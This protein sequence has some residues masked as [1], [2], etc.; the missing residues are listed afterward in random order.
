M[1]NIKEIGK[2]AKNSEEDAELG[3]RRQASRTTNGREE[4]VKRID[5]KREKTGD[6]ENL[7]PIGNKLAVWIQD[8]VPP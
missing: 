3:V 7:V 1:Q 8:L 6:E 2:R 5:E 4:E